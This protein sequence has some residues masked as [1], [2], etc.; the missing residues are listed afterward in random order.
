MSEAPTLTSRNYSYRQGDRHIISR[1]TTEKKKCFDRDS[2]GIYNKVLTSN[3]KLEAQ[4]R[5]ATLSET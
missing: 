3:S 5:R 2:Q 4:S 1:Y